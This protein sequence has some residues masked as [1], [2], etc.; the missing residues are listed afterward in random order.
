[1]NGVA[2]GYPIDLPNDGSVRGVADGGG[3]RLGRAGLNGNRGG[4]YNN[5]DGRSLIAP[6]GSA[7]AGLEKYR[8]CQAGEKSQGIPDA[9]MA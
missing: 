9:Q 8:E 3:K 4:G 7:C 6:A 2:A 1:M 5:G